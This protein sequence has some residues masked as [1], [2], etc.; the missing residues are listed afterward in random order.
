MGPNATQSRGAPSDAHW[1]HTLCRCELNVVTS[2]IGCKFEM[3]RAHWMNTS[4]PKSP[5]METSCSS[6]RTNTHSV[7][8]LPKG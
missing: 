7:N 8:V 1:I 6:L 4:H 2:V 3:P 5:T